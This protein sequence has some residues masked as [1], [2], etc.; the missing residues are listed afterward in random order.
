MQIVR[1]EAIHLDSYLKA[2]KREVILAEYDGVELP[3]NVAQIAEIEANPESFLAKQDDPEALGGD[4]VLPDG[5]HVPRIPGFTRWMWDGEACGSINFRWQ[6]GTTELPPT[7]LGHIGYEVFPWKRG[8]GYAY[9]ALKQMLPEAK[10]LNLPFVELVADT[11]NLISQKVIVK[12][13]GV[14]HEKF[15]KPESYGGSPD[16]LRYRIYL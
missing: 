4:V 3:R 11:D 13:G 1:P 9:E 15:R 10:K 12:N 7:C 14:F 8:L 5:S 2:L 16:A 6:P